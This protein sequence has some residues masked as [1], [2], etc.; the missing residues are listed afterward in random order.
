ME[1]VF[2]KNTIRGIKIRTGIIKNLFFLWKSSKFFMYQ[3]E[4]T[5]TFSFNVSGV[6]LTSKVEF[7]SHGE[8]R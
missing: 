8:F 7:I 3:L 5:M 4:Q 1:P 2:G 6:K